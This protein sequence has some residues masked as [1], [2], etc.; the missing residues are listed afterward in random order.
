[1]SCK[2]KKE[3]YCEPSVLESTP[4]SINDLPNEILIHILSYLGPDELIHNIAKVSDR[5]TFLA[6]DVQ[7]WKSLSYNCGETSDI[8]RISEVRCSISFG[9]S[10]I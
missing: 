3:V 4:R 6:K 7:L 9:F 1:M 8:S 2:R 5:W 10:T